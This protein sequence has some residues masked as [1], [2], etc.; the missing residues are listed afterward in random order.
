M[1]KIGCIMWCN[2]CAVDC[3]FERVGL[4]QNC[5]HLIENYVNLFL[6]WFS[7][8]MWPPALCDHISPLPWKTGKI[9]NR[10]HE[11]CSATIL[12]ALSTYCNRLIEETFPAPKSQK[13]TSVVDC[14][15]KPRSGQTCIS[16]HLY[17]VKT[18]IMWCNELNLY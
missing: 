6:P 7:W 2:G 3:A 14:G 18:C 5:P 15:F 13:N 4:V 1:P 9:I 17:Y 16:D 11:I 12:Y 8:K 10:C